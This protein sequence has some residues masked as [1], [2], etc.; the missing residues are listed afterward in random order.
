[1]LAAE[2]IVSVLAAGFGGGETAG[3]VDRFGLAV[4][5]VRIMFPM[6]ALL[7]LAAWTLGVLNSHRRFFLPYVAPVLWNVAIIA[8]L[9]GTAVWW[10]GSPAGLTP[11]A[12]ALGRLDR[13]LFAGCFGALAGGALQFLVQLP[14]V[15]RVLPHFEWSLSTRVEGVQQALRQFGPIVAGRGVAQLSGYLDMLLA[16]F[17]AVGAL[18]SLRFALILYML[19]VSL[20]GMSVAAAE[21]PELS[22]LTAEQARAFTQRLRR[23][24]RQILFL[25]VPTAIGYLAF[26]WLLVGALFRTGSFGPASQWLVYVVL[27]GYSLGLL[28]TTLS[29]LLQNAFYAVDDAKTPAKV[30]A[31]RVTVSTALAVP[32]MLGLDR[33]AVA[34]VVALPPGAEALYL[35]ALGLSLGASGGA[36]VE[37][38][39]L[40]TVLR[41][42]LPDE[43]VTLALPWGRTG[44]MAGLALAAAG[45]AGA[46]WAGLQGAAPALHVI[47]QAA[48]VVGLYAASYLGGAYALGWPEMNAWVD[49]FRREGA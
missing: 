24:L 32:L 43:A 48:A 9:V 23:S 25:T 2:P 13:L 39:R 42:R 8:G 4:Q 38:A 1:V 21:L 28:A 36:W 26:G 22:R 33:V 6:A 27:G 14:L 40:R 3:G 20:F 41:R 12:W 34:E 45:P 49:R 47:L 16:S 17:L 30:A 46:L 31:L 35:G 11:E 44:R 29:R 37:L 15:V 19:P 10:T 5:A 18:S 7:V